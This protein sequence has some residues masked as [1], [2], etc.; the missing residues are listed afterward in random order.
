MFLKCHK[1]FD[2]ELYMVLMIYLNYIRNQKVTIDKRAGAI[3][4]IADRVWS[5]QEKHLCLERMSVVWF[6]YLCTLDVFS[7]H[8]MGLFWVHKHTFYRSS[9]KRHRQESFLNK[10]KKHMLHRFKQYNNAIR[11]LSNTVTQIVLALRV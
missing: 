2:Y 3:D 10:L 8:P 9:S 6:P 1:N 11:S 7:F 5:C 4:Q